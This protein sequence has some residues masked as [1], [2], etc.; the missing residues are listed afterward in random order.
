[1]DKDLLE[2]ARELLN[3]NLPSTTLSTVDKDYNVNVAVISVLEM[4]DDETIL[5]ARF[6]ADR[7][8][9]NLLSTRKGVFM[10]LTFDEFQ[11]KEGI[12]VAVEMIG[13]ETGGPHYQRM[14]DR[15]DQTRYKRFPLKNCLIFKITGILPISTLK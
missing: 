7:T 1:M 8:Y 3:R 2:K 11:T 9:A 12:R 10:V 14:R 4:I 5:C 13:D 15:L 6:G